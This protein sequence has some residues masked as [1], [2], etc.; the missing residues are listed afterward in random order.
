MQLNND[1]NNLQIYCDESGFTG[2]RLLD[3]DQPIFTFA[4]VASNEQESKYIVEKVI[5]KY[6]IQNGEIKS[7]NL[8][9]SPKGLRALDEILE[10]L[11]G[12]YKICICDKKYVI[13]GKFFEY[14]FEPALAQKNS[15]FYGIN[16]HRFITDYLHLKLVTQD[17]SAEVIF[18]EFY[19]VMKQGVDTPTESLF[20]LVSNQPDPVLS[21]IQKFAHYNKDSFLYEMEGYLGEGAGKWILDI[22]TTCLFSSLG[23][24]GQEID[25]LDVYC[26][27]SKPLNANQEI[28]N[29]MVGRTEKKSQIHEKMNL[30]QPLTFNLKQPVQMVDSKSFYG[31]QLADAIAGSFNYAYKNFKDENNQFAQKWMNKIFQE[32]NILVTFL[33]GDYEYAN[34]EKASA[35]LNWLI[36]N[37]IVQKCDDGLPILDNISDEIL[38]LRQLI[39]LS[40]PPNVKVWNI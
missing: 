20:H 26:D 15:I 22:T 19:T 14:I 34:I 3:A 40:P 24:W 31:I 5:Q 9:K 2:N 18:E 30:E 27:S 11:D 36:L 23:K 28:F 37:H 21:Q 17:K 8:V 12:R 7:G 13:A 6:G 39:L 38:S 29:N 35:M 1:L 25:I 16:F 32:E 4:S 33:G 10:I